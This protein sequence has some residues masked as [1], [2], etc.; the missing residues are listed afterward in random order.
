MILLEQFGPV[1]ESSDLASQFCTLTF[2]RL[3]FVNKFLAATIA[4]SPF[5]QLCLY[6]AGDDLLLD[7]IT[8]FHVFGQC[9][10]VRSHK[11]PIRS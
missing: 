3:H 9:D 2:Q 8:E 7:M 4:T 5:A 10:H 11:L 6:V 1:K